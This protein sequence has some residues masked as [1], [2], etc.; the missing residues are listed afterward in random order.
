MLMLIIDEK[1][2]RSVVCR[3]GQPFSSQRTWVLGGGSLVA[4]RLQVGNPLLG[5]GAGGT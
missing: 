3:P 4:C 5:L 1:R 2:K